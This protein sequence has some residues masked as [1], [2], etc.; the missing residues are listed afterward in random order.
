MYSGSLTLS[1]GRWMVDRG[2][3]GWKVG[4]MSPAA[5]VGQ[6]RRSSDRDREPIDR[7]VRPSI[8][9]NGQRCLRD[10]TAAVP[11]RSPPRRVL[12]SATCSTNMKKT[13]ANIILADLWRP[14]GLRGSVVSGVSDW[15]CTRIINP[16]PPGLLA[17]LWVPGEG[18]YHAPLHA[19]SRT[20]GRRELARWHSTALDKTLQNHLSELKIEVTCEV[21]VR[22][23]VKIRRFDVL[24]PGDQD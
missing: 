16:S 5:C 1:G 24:G 10:V 9:H 18:A 8:S 4:P 21:N 13:L 20:V 14:G 11:R 23:K 3:R 15:N 12:L 19:I 7:P 2:R 22:S 17:H 6:L